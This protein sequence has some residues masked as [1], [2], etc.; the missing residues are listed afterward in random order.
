MSGKYEPPFTVASFATIT[1][2]RP[3]TTPIPVTIPALGACAAVDLPRG[4]RVQLQ[5]C[6]S[7]VDEPVDP[8]AGEQLA[9]CVMAL[10]RRLA[11]AGGHLS[12]P[13]PQLL[14]ERL[15]PG[16]P[17]AK[18]SVCSTRLVSSATGGSLTAR[19]RLWVSTEP[20]TARLGHAV[21]REPLPSLPARRRGARRDRRRGRPDRWS[22]PGGGSSARRRARI[23]T[24]ATTTTAATDRLAR[25][26]PQKGVTLGRATAPVTVQV[27]EDPQC[28]YCK[29]WNVGT[30][31]TVVKDYVRTGKIKLVWR[32]INIIGP[33]SEYGL[34][35]A[36][37][38]GLQ[39]KL[40]QMVDELYARQGAENSGWIDDAVI[41]SSA[42]AAGA[43][44]NSISAAF[45]TAP[46]TAMWE[47]ARRARRPP[48]P[49]T[50]RPPSS[51]SAPRRLPTQLQLSA[52]DPASF[53]AALDPL[54]K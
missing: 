48:T 18:S 19:L 41:S 42:K 15:Q 8:L 13:R 37:A 34:R 21:S 29:D 54:L 32:G 28:P 47:D 45:L 38:A 27:F 11:A 35:A 10:D 31:P 4:E 9:A 30:L 51:S 33:N 5:K 40:W 44:V 39:N 25:G 36:Y 46:V 20:R 12:G 16:P 52:L 2:W 53:A 22:G 6:R 17:A 26:I 50:A 24:T 3:S 1:H 23:T 43:N 49:S 14:H 7:R